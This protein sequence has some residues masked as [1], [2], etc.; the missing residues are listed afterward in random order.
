MICTPCITTN[1]WFWF[2][3]C[4]TLLLI[5]TY[6]MSK[7]A[8][9]FCIKKAAENVP[10]SI[11]DLMLP[12][13][14]KELVNMMRTMPASSKKAVSQHLAIDYLFMLAVYPGIAL[15]CCITA[16]RMDHIGKWFFWLLAALQLFAWLFDVLENI[17]LAQKLRNPVEHASEQPF[18][19]FIWRVKAKF[20]LGF[21]GAICAVF[22]LLYYWL[23]GDYNHDTPWYLLFM[24][25]ELVLF[26]MVLNTKK[27]EVVV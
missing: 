6:I 10:F 20:I 15:L 5:T 1:L 23:T 14:E 7:V 8:R 13:T 24:L 2:S 3:I 9:H 22:A 12:L 19:R 16:N 11:M 26:F 4:F 27:K 25:A 17:Y 18:N 21:A